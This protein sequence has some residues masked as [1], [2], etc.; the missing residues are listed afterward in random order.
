MTKFSTKFSAQ[1]L[2]DLLTREANA[3]RVIRRALVVVFVEADD[4]SWCE[5]DADGVEH[6][7]TL[8]DNWVAT[9]NARGCSCRVVRYPTG[10]PEAKP[11]YMKFAPHDFD[12]DGIEGAV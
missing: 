11:F 3:A 7:K 10:K 1:K 2:G 5:L 8:A 4:G 9:Q 6:A 12:S